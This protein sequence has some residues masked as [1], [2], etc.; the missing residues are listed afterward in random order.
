M[1]LAEEVSSPRMT[2][3]V[4]YKLRD[5]MSARLLMVL[6]YLEN[7]GQFGTIWRWRAYKFHV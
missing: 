7:T 3:T 1:D 2:Q 6:D 5:N 4:L